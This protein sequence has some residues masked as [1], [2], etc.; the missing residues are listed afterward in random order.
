M[1]H[2]SRQQFPSHVQIKVSNPRNG[3]LIGYLGD[4]S[5]SGIKIFSDLPFVRD[6]R[7]RMKIHSD[8]IAQ[9]ALDAICRWSDNDD[10]QEHFAGGFYLVKPP[11][12]FTELV[13]KLRGQRSSN[14]NPVVDTADSPPA[15]LS[16]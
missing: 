15:S 4:V 10:E 3:A 6:E 9:L 2:H 8:G 14:E 1:R 16:A 5:E 7:M 13:K 12:G 11:A